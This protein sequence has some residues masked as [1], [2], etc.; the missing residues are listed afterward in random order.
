MKTEKRYLNM[1]IESLQ[2]LAADPETQIQSLPEY[3]HI[4]DEIALIFSDT[5]LLIYQNKDS[6][7]LSDSQFQKLTEIDKYLNEMSEEN[8]QIWTLEAI[9]E[10]DKWKKLRKMAL[11]ILRSLNIKKQNPNLYWIKYIEGKEP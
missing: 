7:F 10:N 5:F 11:E 6:L 2:L 3:V 1:I 8:H 4:P 9:K